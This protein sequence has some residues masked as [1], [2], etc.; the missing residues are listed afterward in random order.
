M[1]I[2]LETTLQAL[3]ED[4]N[5]KPCHS[6]ARY[7]DDEEGTTGRR[8]R[9]DEERQPVRPPCLVIRQLKSTCTPLDPT[10]FQKGKS[11]FLTIELL[12][13]SENDHRT[14]KPVIFDHSF[15]ETGHERPWTV[16]HL[17]LTP[18]HAGF[19]ATYT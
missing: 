6:T 19:D 1:K 15:S 2:L 11:P 10:Q 9:T 14:L 4:V 13:K 12:A 7:T 3:E 8:V 5:H 16:V 18:R 17:V